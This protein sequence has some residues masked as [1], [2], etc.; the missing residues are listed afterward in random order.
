MM[1]VEREKGR[2][3]VIMDSHAFRVSFTHTR[4]GMRI[5]SPY[6]EKIFYI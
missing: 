4:M 3:R 5:E 1:A 2:K 6:E